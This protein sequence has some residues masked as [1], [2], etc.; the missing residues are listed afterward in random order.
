[1]DFVFKF[2]QQTNLLHHQF[3]RAQPKMSDSIE[4]IKQVNPELQ[5]SEE[6][7]MSS[8]DSL[9][10]KNS[11]LNQSS[12]SLVD[13][14]LGNSQQ[15]EVMYC[16]K[17]R[18]AQKIALPSFIDETVDNWKEKSR[19]GTG[20]QQSCDRKSS[21]QTPG[22]HHKSSDQTPGEHHKSTEMIG[23]KTS[24]IIPIL[25]VDNETA[26]GKQSPDDEEKKAN[27]KLSTCNEEHAKHLQSKAC[28]SDRLDQ[29]T[30]QKTY[31]PLPSNHSL[32]TNTQSLDES[33]RESIL[34]DLKEVNKQ[35]AG[36]KTQFASSKQS[37]NKKKSQKINEN[38]NSFDH[39]LTDDLNE[40][41]EIKRSSSA[42]SPSSGHTSKVN[43]SKLQ[44]RSTRLR[45]A[46]GETRMSKQVGI[47]L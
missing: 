6:L 2:L 19:S 22:E 15:Y 30:Y 1:M 3:I 41:G 36:L 14:I 35:Q 27:R 7:G 29:T 5:R 42:N 26:A 4:I 9:L 47:L 23:D 17:V 40:L 21:D 8:A 34:S 44:M 12:G 16:G 46:S 31:L 37:P 32:I 33:T 10:P 38:L 11:E 20:E 18:V 25:S 24:S 28:S 39:L 43:A 13:N 45:S